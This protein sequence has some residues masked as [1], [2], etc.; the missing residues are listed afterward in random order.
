MR[1]FYHF[2]QIFWVAFCAVAMGMQTRL[3]LNLPLELT[4]MEGFVFCGTIF[5]YHCTHANRWYSVLAWAAGWAGGL[6]YL[7]TFLQHP[8]GWGLHSWALVPVFFWLAY[9][10]FERPGRVGL[11]AHPIAKPLTVAITWAWVTV[12][13]P[14]ADMPWQSLIW[15]G[16]GRAAF[17][18]VLALAYD[19]S[20]LQYD[21]ALGLQTWTGKLGVKRSFFLIYTGL[22]ISAGFVLLN[23]LLGIFDIWEASILLVSLLISVFWLRGVLLTPRWVPWQKTLIDGLMMLQFVLV[24]L[25][26]GGS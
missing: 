11:R 15:I 20:D 12:L 9:Y 1:L 8:S 25:L 5:G 3:L 6:L 7:S 21:Q 4:W 22:G 10:G 13:L 2:F 19:L 26:T 24:V 18:F 14:A 16:A 17:I 23:A